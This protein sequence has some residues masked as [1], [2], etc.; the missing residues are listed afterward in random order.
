MAQAQRSFDP[1]E[2][3]AGTLPLPA[4]P[5][6]VAVGDAPVEWSASPAR[7]LHQ[8][9]LQSFGAPAASRPDRLPVGARLA[10]IGAAVMAPWVAIVGAWVALA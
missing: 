7:A 9:L 2:V 1:V 4:A 5:V 8:Q 6:V 3:P 10:I